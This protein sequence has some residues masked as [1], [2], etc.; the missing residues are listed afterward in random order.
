MHDKIQRKNELLSIILNFKLKTRNKY[1][2]KEKKMNFLKF[3]SNKPPKS[4]LKLKSIENSTLF[5]RRVSKEHVVLIDGY[6]INNRN[7]LEFRPQTKTDKNVY[8]TNTN[9]T[10]NSDKVSQFGF[11]TRPTN[12]ARHGSLTSSSGSSTTGGV[13]NQPAKKMEA[14]TQ[15]KSASYQVLGSVFLTIIFHCISLYFQINQKLLL[16]SFIFFI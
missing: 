8:P 10:T 15:G 1:A 12:I 4:P 5:Q 16:F 11:V 3:N 13:V 6:E 9:V 7:I 14:S 2:I